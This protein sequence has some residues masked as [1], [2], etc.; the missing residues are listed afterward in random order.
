MMGKVNLLGNWV[1]FSIQQEENRET[2]K[3]T[4]AFPLFPLF[5]ESESIQ[6]EETEKTEKKIYS[7]F[8]VSSCSRDS[9]LIGRGLNRKSPLLHEPAQLGS[10]VRRDGQGRGTETGFDQPSSF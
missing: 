10:I 8:S 9:G 1:V 5:K 7:V 6:Q 3:K 4:T 2:K